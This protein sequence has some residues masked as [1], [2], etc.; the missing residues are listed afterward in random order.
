MVVLVLQVL[1]EGLVGLCFWLMFEVITLNF[2]LN[3]SELLLV[4]VFD[5][6]KVS[7]LITALV[8]PAMVLSQS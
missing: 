8:V 5:F 6:K 4:I 3:G 7:V 1:V 2:G